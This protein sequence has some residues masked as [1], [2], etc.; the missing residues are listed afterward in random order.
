VRSSNDRRP[1]VGGSNLPTERLTY[2]QVPGRIFGLVGGG[3]VVC[4]GL[5]VLIAGAVETDGTLPLASG[6]III[7]VSVPMLVLALSKNLSKNLRAV[8]L[9]DTTQQVVRWQK[10]QSCD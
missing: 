6:A 4:M 5:G 9:T 1:V 7:A 2:R 8:V 10:L 3:V